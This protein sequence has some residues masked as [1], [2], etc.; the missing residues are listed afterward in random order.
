MPNSDATN[1]SSTLVSNSSSIVK[2]FTSRSFYAC[3]PTLSPS[4]MILE[5]SPRHPDVS[6]RSLSSELTYR[7][8]RGKVSFDAS[9]FTFVF[10]VVTRSHHPRGLLSLYLI[11]NE[12]T[13]NDE[14]GRL[15][16]ERILTVS[17]VVLLPSL[18]A[19]PPR[20]SRADSPL[21][22][23]IVLSSYRAGISL[24]PK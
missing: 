15:G 11:L 17:R 13:Q 2:G 8:E 9:L 4:F 7:S 14:L 22:L 19:S 3:I 20:I 23:C 18:L 6:M 16:R 10:L 24:H 1:Q 5:S 12:G 21:P